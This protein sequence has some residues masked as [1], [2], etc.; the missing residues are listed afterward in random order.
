MALAKG[1]SSKTK[2]QMSDIRTI[3]PLVLILTG[4][5]DENNNEISLQNC[6]KDFTC[7]YIYI[8][9]Q[10]NCLPLSKCGSHLFSL[11]FRVSTTCWKCLKKLD[12]L[13]HFKNHV[14]TNRGTLSLKCQ[15]YLNQR[16]FKRVSELKLLVRNSHAE[17]TEGMPDD[18]FSKPNAFFPQN[19]VG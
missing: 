8:N 18:L 10:T 1:H 2:S 5:G 14:A 3:G 16:T 13:K 9:F 17:T 12:S 15:F 6:Y 19:T 11:C 7:S 4:G